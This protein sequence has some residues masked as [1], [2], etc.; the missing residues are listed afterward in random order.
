MRYTPL[1]IALAATLLAA[2]AEA[3]TIPSPFRYVETTQAAGLWA[4]YLRFSQGDLG[5]RP[6][7]APFFGTQYAIRLTGPLSGTGGLAAIPTRRT[8]FERVVVSGDEI[9]LE[10][11]GEADMLLLLL[12]GGLRF[13][14]TGARTWNGLAPYVGATG[15]VMGNV[16]GRPSVEDDI[17]SAQ[18]V[19][20]GPSFAFGVNA[21]TD[22]FLTERLSLRTEARHY[23]WRFTT[24]EGF[25]T[26]QSRTAEWT[27]NTGITFGAALHF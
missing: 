1:K 20:F 18:R 9:E 17:P 15:G 23:L 12:E 10:P 6:E 13:V 7:S 8:V 26:N 21:G 27:Q 25:T 2:S 16:L 5:I 11:V 3:Q 4:G 14:V 19:S 24:P 22:W